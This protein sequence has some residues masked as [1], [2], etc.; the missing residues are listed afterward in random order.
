MFRLWSSVYNKTNGFNVRH[1]QT[2]SNPN[3]LLL[4]RNFTERMRVLIYYVDHLKPTRTGRLVGTT[5]LW[6]ART[7]WMTNKFLSFVLPPS[8]CALI[9]RAAR[10]TLRLSCS[11]SFWRRVCSCCHC[12]LGFGAAS[13][14]SLFWRCTVLTN[15]EYTQQQSLADARILYGLFFVLFWYSLTLF[16]STKLIRLWF[17]FHSRNGAWNNVII[18]NCSLPKNLW[19]DRRHARCRLKEVSTIFFFRSYLDDAWIAG[20]TL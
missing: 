14:F 11:S 5:D 17:S 13:S 1:T 9:P 19:Q 18:F 7:D 20:D 15:F 2:L 6:K 16:L 10:T 4:E 12:L 3:A 8:L